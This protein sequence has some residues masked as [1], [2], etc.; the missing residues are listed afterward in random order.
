MQKAK[1]LLKKKVKEGEVGL[2]DTQ[3][4]YKPQK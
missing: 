1:A 2:Y 4:D 3:T